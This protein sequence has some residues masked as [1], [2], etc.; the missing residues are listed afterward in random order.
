MRRNFIRAALVIFCIG[1]TGSLRSQP[2]SAGFINSNKEK[3][4]NWLRAMHLQ[5]YIS[6]DTVKWEDPLLGLYLGIKGNKNWKGLTHFLDSAEHIHLVSWLFDEFAFQ[7]ELRPPDKGKL[8][9]D[10]GDV[11]TIV[12]SYN[13]RLR[14]DVLGAQGVD[15]F[16]AYTFSGQKI[17][18]APV[19]LTSGKSPE[20][21][22][23]LIKPY[24]ADYFNSHKTDAGPYDFEDV[25]QDSL[26]LSVLIKN[27]KKAVL[28]ND[29]FEYLE[30]TFDFTKNGD[31]TEILFNLNGKYAADIPWTPYDDRY[32]PM[33]PDYQVEVEQ[34]MQAMANKITALVN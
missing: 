16:P 34:F 4:R 10:A 13:G 12:K 20:E 30:L 22:K 17:P 19:F 2:M 8:V 32:R 21:L 29:S 7:F 15:E 18:G 31:L 14:E 6:L 25:S 1:F 33:I 23:S 9:A 28:K 5:K 24:L 11:L 27:V 3:Y 26:T